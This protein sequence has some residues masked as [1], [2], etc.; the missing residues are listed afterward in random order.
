MFFI[1]DDIQK[2]GQTNSKLPIIATNNQ[3]IYL[4]MPLWMV[5]SKWGLLAIRP[6]S[7]TWDA[8]FLDL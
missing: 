2:I 7:T 6:R 3:K 1:L 4:L 8:R 5:P